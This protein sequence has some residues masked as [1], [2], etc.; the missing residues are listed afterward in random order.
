MVEF[1]SFFSGPSLSVTEQACLAI[2]VAHG[3]TFRLYAYDSLQVPPGVELANAA[4]TI[5]VAERDAFFSMEIGQVQFRR[6]SQFSNGFRYRLLHDQGRLA[7]RAGLPFL[8][9]KMRWRVSIACG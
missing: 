4:S 8:Q 9:L 6:I 7:P 3:H 1:R 2:S 5:P